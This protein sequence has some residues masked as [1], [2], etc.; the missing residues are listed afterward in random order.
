MSLECVNKMPELIEFKVSINSYALSASSLSELL[1]IPSTESKKV[2]TGDCSSSALDL[3]KL[4][5]NKCAAGVDLAE[6]FSKY[7]SEISNNSSETV[8][9]F[10]IKSDI[11]SSMVC[12][13]LCECLTFKLSNNVRNNFS[14][15]SSARSSV[16]ST[17]TCV[18]VN[19]SNKNT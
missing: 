1:P 9:V 17:K 19:R 13:T 16:Q 6:L 15:M 7:A 18:S 2:K 10:A 12:C 5:A 3:K 4:C 11:N 8:S 14:K